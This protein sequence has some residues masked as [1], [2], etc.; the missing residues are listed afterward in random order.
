MIAAFHR[1]PPLT[2]AVAQTTYLLSSPL[3][4]PAVVRVGEDELSPALARRMA[5]ALVAAA[6]IAEGAA[7]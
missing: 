2:V 4:M 5:T 1:E 3:D 6:D 7:R